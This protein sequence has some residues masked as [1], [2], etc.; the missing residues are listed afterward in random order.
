M[1]HR[2]KE[3]P[4]WRTEYRV[5]LNVRAAFCGVDKRTKVGVDNCVEV[6]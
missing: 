1:K 5:L 6:E 2:K 3:L 4:F